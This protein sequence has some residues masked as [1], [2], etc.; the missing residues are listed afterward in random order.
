[1]KKSTILRATS[2]AVAAS[3]VV[4]LAGCAGGADAGT[5]SSGTLNVTLANHPWS[6]AVKKA[7]PDF[8]KETGIK[9]DLNIYDDEQLAQLYNVKLNAASDELDVMMFKPLQDT[10]QMSTNKWLVDL[11][12]DVTKDAGW[13]WQ[14]FQES[15]RSSVTVGD[16]VVGV[17]IATETAVLYYRKDLLA[18]AGLDV[19]KTMDELTAAVKK[20]HE[21]NPDIYA[22]GAR[23][24]KSAAV[25]Q[26]SSFLYSFGGDWV[27]K[28]GKAAVDSPEAIKAYEYLG[29]LI[30]DYGP[31]G[32]VDMNWPQVMGL[33]QQGLVAFYPEGSSQYNNA[34]D[35]SKSNI[36]DQIGVAPIPSGSDGSRPYNI[37]NFAI[38]INSGSKN[39]D[40]AWKFIQWATSKD[41]VLK[42]QQADVPGPRTSVWA[43]PA[44]TSALPADLLK[45][46]QTNGDI[47]VGYDRPVLIAVAAAREA[48]GTPLVT[49]I[50]GGDV[51]DAAKTANA[52]FQD[53]LDKEK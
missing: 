46:I 40:N 45:V 13:D 34:V 38:G 42:F 6:D 32:S 27:D 12:D 35:P 5:G 21:L 30:K 43:D 8:E 16:E 37:T 9:V 39:Q 14:D 53:L 18:A 28:N 41:N 29:G 2:L 4:A 20:I 15:A 24:E 22:F 7:L 31:P 19:P 11:S 1:M 49:A 52:A 3:A 23:G 10:L 47:G 17:P 51:A 26:F 48:V 33:M 50:Q 36:A 44:G 25:T